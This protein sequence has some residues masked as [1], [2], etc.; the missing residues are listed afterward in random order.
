MS[1][2]ETTS[3]VQVHLKA[4]ST[5]ID[6]LEKEILQLNGEVEILKKGHIP[7]GPTVIITSETYK[8]LLKRSAMLTDIEA[9]RNPENWGGQEKADLIKKLDEASRRAGN[10]K[11]LAEQNSFAYTNVS[12]MHDRLFKALQ[13]VKLHFGLDP[14][15]NPESVLAHIKKLNLTKD[16]PGAN[17]T[18]REL[19]NSIEKEKG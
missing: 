8:D 7:E 3:R 9:S 2:Y 15:L 16:L 1:A 4:T 13:D 19:A 17:N 11:V 6:Q 10:F 18:L 5:L 14:Y 12:Q